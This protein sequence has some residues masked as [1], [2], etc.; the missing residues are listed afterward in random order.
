MNYYNYF[1]EIEEAFVRRRGRHL[2][3]SPLDWSLI[4]SWQKRGVPLRLVLRGI[5]TVFDSVGKD[6]IRLK[7][8]KSLS[9]CKNEI[10]SIYRDWLASNVGKQETQD[11][12]SVARK[13]ATGDHTSAPGLFAENDVKFHLESIIR[14]LN[15]ARPYKTELVDKTLAKIVSELEGISDLNADVF[16]KLLNTPR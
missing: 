7:G 16:E 4:E 9:Y 2:S 3:L 11:Y 12:D 14:E 15:S 6:P 5:N 10:E 13:G 8:I 1:T